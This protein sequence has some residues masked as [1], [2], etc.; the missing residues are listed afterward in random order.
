MCAI[1]R[2][3]GAIRKKHGGF[4]INRAVFDK[5]YKQALKKGFSWSAVVP[6]GNDETMLAGTRVFGSNCCDADALTRAELEGR[7]QVRAVCDLLREHFL[8]GKG[9]PLVTLPAKIGIR[10][11]R[12]ARCLHTLTV[13][14]VLGGIRFADAIANG[15]Y[16]VD[17]HSA[18]GAGVKFTDLKDTTFYQIPYR[19]LVPQGSKNVLVAG[20]CLDA[21]EGAFGAVR[22]MVNCNQ[23]GQA[24]GVAA[25]L[26]LDAGVDVADV[27]AARLRAVLGKQGALVVEAERP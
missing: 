23:M 12:H 22:V 8:D 6:G 19:S 10:E 21:D 3:L 17:V 16:R 26:A 24:A 11:T 25:H 13:K 14:E 4:S 20:R 15:S 27:D 18:K 9:V 7:R 5:Q 1:L 2:G